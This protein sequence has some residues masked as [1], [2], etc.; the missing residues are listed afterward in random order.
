[1]INHMD[2]ARKNG[3]HADGCRLNGYY[4]GTIDTAT[5]DFM[6]YFLLKDGREITISIDDIELDD[7]LLIRPGEKIPTDGEVVD[8]ISTVDEAMVT[9]ES[10][11]VVKEIGHKVIGGCVSG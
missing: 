1:M 8:G 2:D 6:P 11:P 10:I 5:D 3:I 9:G 7:H 4:S